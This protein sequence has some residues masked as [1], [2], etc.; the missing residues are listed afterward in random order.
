MRILNLISTLTG[1]GAERQLAYLSRELRRRGHDIHVGYSH[2]GPGGWPTDLGATLFPRRSPWNVRRVRDTVALIGELQPEIIQ[3][4]SVATDVI[5]GLAAARSR[6]PWIIRE[7]SHPSARRPA[8]IEALRLVIARRFVS[9]IVANSPGGVSYWR[10]QA[11]RVPVGFLPNALPQADT[12]ASL[13]AAAATNGRSSGIFVGRLDAEKNVDVII[14]AAAR[15]IRDR[16]FTLSICGEGPEGERLQA[17]ARTL[18]VDAHVRFLGYQQDVLSHLRS[19]SLSVLVSDVE[20]TPN[21]VLEAFA[22][23]T[24]VVLSDIPAHRDLAPPESVMFVGVKDVAGTADAMTHV[25]DHPEAAAERANRARSAL[26][27]HSMAAAGDALEDFCLDILA[28]AGRR[29]I[30]PP[31]SSAS[32]PRSSV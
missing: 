13:S 29:L 6:V 22:S 12:P 10:S 5:G 23:G 2:F 32:S 4:W 31:G 20:G 8:R 21:A 25:L 14:S 15:I 28:R 24:P 19:A 17:L 7:S 30:S 9:G 1:G 16:D 11:T 18:G 26:T 3:T 27:T